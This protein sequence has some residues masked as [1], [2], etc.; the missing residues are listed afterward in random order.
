MCICT[1]IFHRRPVT[2]FFFLFINH[3]SVWGLINENKRDGD[4]FSCWLFDWTCKG[5]GSEVKS[6]TC[7]EDCAVLT[8]EYSNC[9]RGVPREQWCEVSTPNS[10]FPFTLLFE[11]HCGTFFVN[12]ILF[13]SSLDFDRWIKVLPLSHELIQIETVVDMF[14]ACS[15]PR[16]NSQFLF[17]PIFSTSCI[18]HVF[19]FDIRLSNFEAF[20]YL[21]SR[22]I[23]FLA[24]A[25]KAIKHVICCFSQIAWRTSDDCL[26]SLNLN[27]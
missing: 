17:C 19:Y 23:N 1:N 27:N 15:S 12:E 14:F 11:K 7:F 21:R 6:G 3:V 26:N 5:T 18:A 13:R 4:W 2:P 20:F 16:S 10:S 25:F 9:F 24:Y 22:N 8:Y